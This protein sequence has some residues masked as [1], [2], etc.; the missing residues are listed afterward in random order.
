MHRQRMLRRVVTVSL[1]TIASCCI[2]LTRCGRGGA[3]GGDRGRD[4]IRQDDADSAVP[5]RA[6][7]QQP[8]Q[9]RMHT[10]AARGCHE[11]RRARRGRDG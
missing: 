6:R 4:G 3:G 11:R 1:H 5:A 9:D 8:G 7:L 2:T 10:A